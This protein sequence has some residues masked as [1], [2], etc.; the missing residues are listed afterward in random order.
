MLYAKD[1][2]HVTHDEVRHFDKEE[3]KKIADT[4]KR[5]IHIYNLEKYEK[6]QMKFLLPSICM[7]VMNMMIKGHHYKDEMKK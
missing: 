5:E 6:D 4:L 7:S 2:R 3:A 1:K